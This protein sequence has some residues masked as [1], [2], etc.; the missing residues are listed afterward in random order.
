MFIVFLILNFKLFLELMFYFYFYKMFKHN[1][2]LNCEYFIF[3]LKNLS[4]K[5]LHFKNNQKF[6]LLKIYHFYINL[7]IIYILLS[8]I[9]SIILE[10]V[11]LILI[12]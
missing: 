2:L 9:S 6:F 10:E 4:S 1:S 5:S 12:H 7:Y 3:P 11:L 8:E